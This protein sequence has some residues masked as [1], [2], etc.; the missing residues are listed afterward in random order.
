MYYP[1][2]L[3]Y[4]NALGV[5]VGKSYNANAAA[6]SRIL[7]KNIHLNMQNYCFFDG[8]VAKMDFWTTIKSGDPR[9]VGMRWGGKKPIGTR[10]M[11]TVDG[12]GL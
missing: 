6:G 4:T 9:P 5:Y 3:D 8:H 7:T 12:S 11:W 2:D 10:N 1:N